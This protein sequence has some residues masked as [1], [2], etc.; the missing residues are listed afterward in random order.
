MNVLPVTFQMAAFGRQP[1]VLGENRLIL[2][3]SGRV[4]TI[5]WSVQRSSRNRSTRLQI[6]SCVNPLYTRDKRSLYC[7]GSRVTEWKNDSEVRRQLIHK[8]KS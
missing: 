3:M 2:S 8:K 7:D 4:R 5:T 1:K 6:N